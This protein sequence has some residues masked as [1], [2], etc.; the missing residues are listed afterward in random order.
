MDI[1]TLST[2]GRL[3]ELFK[4]LAVESRVRIIE[5]LKSGP[6]CVNALARELGM[7]PAGVSQHLRVL[8][9]A[10][11]VIPDK[12]GYHIHY[13]LNQDTLRRWERAVALFF[14]LGR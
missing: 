9:S 8:R 14:D 6:K 11:L 5:Y 13:S 2:A 7:T 12:R 10:E 1:L 4:V 3:S